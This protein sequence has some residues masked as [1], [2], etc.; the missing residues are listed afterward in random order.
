MGVSDVM[1]LT[2]TLLRILTFSN[3]TTTVKLLFVRHRPDSNSPDHASVLLEALSKHNRHG[4][5]SRSA[6]LSNLWIS[7]SVTNPVPRQSL[8]SV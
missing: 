6:C 3:D 7:A 4:P 2:E 5:G 1:S 8:H